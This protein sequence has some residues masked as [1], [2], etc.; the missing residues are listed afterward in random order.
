MSKLTVRERRILV[1]AK[2]ALHA[3]REIFGNSCWND[4]DRWAFSRL[5]RE[6]K[7]MERQSCSR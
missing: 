3:Y 6:I 4:L 7:R 1:A 5:G 2:L